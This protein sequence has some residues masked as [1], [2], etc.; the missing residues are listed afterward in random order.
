MKLR[1]AAMLAIASA[2]AVGAEKLFLGDATHQTAWWFHVPGFP[3]IFGFVS[4]LAL[5]FI[6]K[7]LGKYW[8]QRNERYYQRGSRRRE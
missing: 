8:L 2:V 4:C 6:A 7:T 1:D 5:A 3:A